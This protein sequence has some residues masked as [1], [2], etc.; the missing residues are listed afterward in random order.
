VA[1][2]SLTLSQALAAAIAQMPDAKPFAADVVRQE[3]RLLFEFEFL[4]AD[5]RVTQVAVDAASGEVL[6]LERER[7]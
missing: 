1:T 6:K 2:A 7:Q 5:N 4:T 3:D